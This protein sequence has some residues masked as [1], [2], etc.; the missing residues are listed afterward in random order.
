M[1][2]EHSNWNQS[3]VSRPA[4][5]LPPASESE[6]LA[7]IRDPEQ[8]PPPVRA[9]GHWHSLNRSIEAD[10]GT[11][12]EMEAFTGIHV[13]AKALTL[14]AGAGTSLIRIAEALLRLPAPRH[15]GDRQRHRRLDRVLRHEGFFDRRRTR[16]GQLGGGGDADR[17]SRRAEMYFI[18]RDAGSPL[19]V[20]LSRPVM[21][22][23]LRQSPALQPGWQQLRQQAHPRFTSGYFRDLGL[24]LALGLAP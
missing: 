3:A 12:V 10:G 1:N 21:D 14:T 13:D 24:G 17:D 20:S 18:R 23:V 11:Q 8:F 7:I 19:S 2:P 5:L 6:L 16:P 4:K 15:A 9:A 22:E